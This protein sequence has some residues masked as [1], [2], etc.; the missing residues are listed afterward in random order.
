MIGVVSGRK[1]N[2]EAHKVHEEGGALPLASWKNAHHDRA[3]R[4]RKSMSLP[5]KTHARF[6]VRFVR[7]VVN[8]PPAAEAAR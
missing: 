4:G 5:T 1:G 8:P 7:F 3:G 6:F 2:H